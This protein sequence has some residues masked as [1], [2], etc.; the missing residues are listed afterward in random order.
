MRKIIEEQIQDSL[1]I[2]YANE[3]AYMNELVLYRLHFEG[4][5]YDQVIGKLV[6]VLINV[7]YKISPMQATIVTTSY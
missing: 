5:K 7:F 4:Y 1:E 3:E 2:A 6:K